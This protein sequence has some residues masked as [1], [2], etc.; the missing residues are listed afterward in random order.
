MKNFSFVKIGTSLV[1]PL[2]LATSGCVANA[3]AWTEKLTLQK[4]ELPTD[5]KG[6]EKIDLK[7]RTRYFLIREDQSA[8]V[9]IDAHNLRGKNLGCWN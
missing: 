2:L 6:W 5:C 1:I 8:L 4:V 7:T 9:N 3:T